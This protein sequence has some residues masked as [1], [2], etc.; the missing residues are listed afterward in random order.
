[1]LKSPVRGVVKTIRA[2]TLGGVVAAGAPVMELMPVGPRMLVEARIRPADIGFVKVG[3]SV[4]VKLS[5]YEYTVYGGIKGKVQSIS[6]DAL[7]DPDR[8]AT[9]EAT[10]YRALIRADRSQ[11]KKG[12]AAL[13]VL[14]GMNGTVDINTGQRTVL[15][16]L[17]RPMLKSQEAFRER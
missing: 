8:P 7:G 10:Y 4:T 3:Q 16:F 9:A 11:L 13:P 5:A 17:L 6:P 15:S 14:P 2:N 1:V 12:D